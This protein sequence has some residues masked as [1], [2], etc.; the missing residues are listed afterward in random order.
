[1]RRF[2]LIPVLLL[3]AV[4]G[5][6]GQTI[7]GRLLEL[8]TDEPIVLGQVFLLSGG[9]TILDQTFTDEGG[10][11]SVT[12]SFPGSFF[13]RAE[14][15]GYESRVDGVFDLGEEG[16]LTVEF[17]LR[18]NPIQ[19][20]TIAV[21]VEGR[22]PKLTILGF[23]DRQ[24]M[25]FGTF[26]GPEELERR[27][28]TR[29]TDFLRNIPRVR[30]R[31][32]PFSGSEIVIQGAASVSLSGGGLCY[33]KVVIDGMEVSRGGNEP[34]RPD[35]FVRPVEI[36]GIEVYRGPSETPLQFGGLSGP[37]GVILIWTR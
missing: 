25:G 29:T 31:E 8:G 11:F 7:Q 22:V 20:D 27:P 34:A 19:L 36:T 24:R 33:P 35:E 2:S 6:H 26:L 21:E 12:S 16:V 14:R 23:Y 15:L 17:R 13:L 18:G 32:R 4:S 30:I 3:L 9:G 5:L 28:V 1:M 10:G 37:C